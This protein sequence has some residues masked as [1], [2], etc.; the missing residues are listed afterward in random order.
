MKYNPGIHHRRSIRLKDYD[1]SQAGLYF[2][3]ICTQGR[4]CLFGDIEDDTVKLT[5]AGEMARTVWE[6]I[7]FH[8]PGV[9][10]DEFVIMPNHFHGIVIIVGAGPRACPDG[11]GQPRGVAP[12]QPQTGQSGIGQ[13]QTGQSGIGQPQI[14]QSGIGHPQIGQ[15]GI[16]QPQI[17]QSGIGHPQIG[18]SGIGHPQGGAPT[19]SLP[20][21]LHRFKTM[22]T[23]KYVDGV[24]QHG[25]TPFSGKLWQRNYWEHIIR[26]EQ[27]LS[28][29]RLYIQNNPLQWESDKLNGGS[30]NRVLE[31]QTEYGWES[32]KI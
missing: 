1:Y 6:E 22:T 15:S 7:P 18:Q 29:I 26:N 8:Y 27:E 9:E 5:A 11:M 20:D 17:G 10:L 13:P 19:M 30:G 23:K 16:G 28:N 12:T 4:H 24:K 2:V 31:P 25:W 32:W 14:G 3:T 21:V